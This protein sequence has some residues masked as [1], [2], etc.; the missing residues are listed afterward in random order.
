MF[1]SPWVAR[2]REGRIALRLPEGLAAALPHLGEELSALLES[3]SDAVRRVFPTA[4]PD[5]PEREAGYQVMV[6]GE[7]IDRHREGIALIAATLDQDHLTDEQ[8][9]AWLTTVNALR[10][11]LG[12]VLGIEDDA[13][14]PD[15][16]DD[17]PRLPAWQL[18]HVLSLLLEDIVAALSS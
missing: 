13:G 12:A 10:L 16:T 14:E 3:D 5:D 17:D 6:R 11:V 15:L 18:Y 9:G 8:L 2:D 1:R 4:Y 7:L